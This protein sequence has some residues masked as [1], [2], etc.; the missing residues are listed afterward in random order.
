MRTNV[1]ELHERLRTLFVAIFAIVSIATTAHAAV[2]DSIPASFAIRAAQ[3][4]QE[5]RFEEA[6]KSIH[7][8]IANEEEKHGM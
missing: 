6:E 4:C 2:L 5:G 8:A 1:R 3:A 7:Q